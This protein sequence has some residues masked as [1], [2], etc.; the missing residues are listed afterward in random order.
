[1]SAHASRGPQ[2][3]MPP[4]PMGLGKSWL[5]AVLAHAV[6]LVGLAAVTSW[7][8]QKEQPLSASAELWSSLPTVRPA[9]VAAEPSPET[10]PKAMPEPEPEPKPA[11][12][13]EPSADEPKPAPKADIRTE[14]AK[15]KPEP[16]K[17]AAE[18]KKTEKDKRK[19]QEEEQRIE[20]M[21]ADN[22]KRLQ[23]LAQAAEGPSHNQ[24]SDADQGPSDAYAGRVRARIKPNIVFTD[25]LPGNP[26]AD[27]QVR[28]SP[29][30][31]IISRRL[32]KSSGNAKWDQAVLAAI[33]KTISLPRDENGKVPSELILSFRPK[34]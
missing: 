27:A 33:D 15:P 18:P 21:R 7:H 3:P 12:R 8:R 10:A 29:S 14:K 2:R 4:E 13:P 26:V 23:N 6:L 9:A 25:D 5:V 31:T 19:A 30:G 16:K 1:M 28:L 22:L 32:I 24:S 17:P 34:D 20:K 11:P